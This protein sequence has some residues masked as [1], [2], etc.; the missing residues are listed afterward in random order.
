LDRLKVPEGVK[1]V[2][3]VSAFELDHKQ[4]LALTAK[5][6]EKLGFEV[7]LIEEKDPSII[8]GLVVSIG[9]LFLDGSLRFKI[10]EAARG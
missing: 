2:K 3:V 1:E 6:K 5:M 8:A 7:K 9:S 10:Q 4:R